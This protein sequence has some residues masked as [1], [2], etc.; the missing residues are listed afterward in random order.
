MN[1]KTVVEL[2]KICKDNKQ[3]YKGFSKCKNK[4]QL[5]TFINTVNNE[6]I[7]SNISNVSN[8]STAS[9]NNYTTGSYHN[10]L[11]MAIQLSLLDNCKKYI[12]NNQIT[13]QVEENIDSIE[14]ETNYCNICYEKKINCVF[15]PCGHMFSC[16][17]CSQKC[18]RRCP[19]CRKNRVKL[20]KI[21]Y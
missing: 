10:D 3:K 14:N 18:N 11:E 4:Q 7:N 17:E 9:T 2:K 1:Q 12:E 21:Y 15:T 19:V 16:Y 6:T 20:L 5:V 13:I 8:V